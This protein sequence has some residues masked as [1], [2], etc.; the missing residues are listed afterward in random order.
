MTIAGA[1]TGYVP[2]VGAFANVDIGLFDMKATSF[3]I[4]A[5]TI[6][7][8]TTL[9]TLSVLA[10]DGFIAISSLGGAGAT[11]TLTGTANQIIIS[12][13]NG[14]GGDPVFSTP[15]DI[16]TTSSPTFANITDSG[17]TANRIVCAGTSG[18]LTGYSTFTISPTTGALVKSASA[19]DANLNVITASGIL[20]QSSSAAR[21]I[22]GNITTIQTAIAAGVSNSTI[23]SG[24]VSA[25]YRNSVVSTNDQGSLTELTGF[26]AQVGHTNTDLYSN[27]LTSTVY[28]YHT[29]NL[30]YRRGTITTFSEVN[31]IN[32]ATISTPSN[33]AAN[34]VYTAG[35]SIVKPTV[36]NGYYYIC[37]VSG[38]SDLTTEPTWP[39]TSTAGNTPATLTDGTVTWT[40][41]LVP[42]ITTLN[43]IKIANLTAGTNNWSLDIGTAPSKFA[44]TIN[45]AAAV[46]VAAV[47]YAADAQA[48]DTY[49]IT[50][51]PAPAAYTTGMHVTFKAATANTGAASLNVNSLGAKTIVKA[52]STT[53]ANNDILANMFCLVVYDGT[54]FVLM[55]PRVL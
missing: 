17:L 52:V 41:L 3:T 28:A 5:N 1:S 33:W 27:P 12:N 40:E 49:V 55:N 34:T 7:D 44:G 48:S 51:S 35:T 54:N 11:R 6:T 15:Q 13:G 14:G 53:L 23:C 24:N 37:S 46:T 18:I 26:Q 47:N 2:Y 45:F 50:L 31:L 4:G 43:G 20:T 10:T 22:Q 16:A 19:T 39:A 25:A 36:A 8:F 38:T 30:L 42:S 21:A 32:P 9:D 29:R